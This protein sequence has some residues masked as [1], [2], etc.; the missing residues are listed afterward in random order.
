MD[1]AFIEVL[2]R[3]RDDKG[4]VRFQG[5]TG[6]N[7]G[8]LVVGT[9]EQSETYQLKPLKELYGE[10]PQAGG[11]NPMTE[12]Y[13]PL[14][15][16]IENEILQCDNEVQRQITDGMVLLSVERLALAPEEEQG[17]DRLATRI[18]VALRIVCS[19]NDY[20]RQEVR[21]ALRRIARSVEHHTSE[22]GPRGYLNF[23]HQVM[24]Q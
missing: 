16:G 13:M 3:Y 11:A 12:A 17:D 18:Q 9:G 15:H 23:L 19:L 6:G 5:K 2:D 4:G 10:G 1:Q 20:S 24:P 7:A 14:F 22:G 21:Q 8:E